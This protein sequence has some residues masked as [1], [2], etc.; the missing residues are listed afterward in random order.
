MIVESGIVQIRA[1]EE[2]AF[3]E[4]FARAHLLVKAAEGCLKIELHRG[5]EQKSQYLLLVWW[6]CVEDHTER[7]RSSQNF[8]KWRD[9]VGPFFA[10]PP[11]V[12]HYED[13]LGSGR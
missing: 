13:A 3:E 11:K 4:A 12:L 8:K 7:F 1:G 9:L 6:N 10:T 2:A 5:I